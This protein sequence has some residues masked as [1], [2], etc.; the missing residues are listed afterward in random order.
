MNTFLI[1]ILLA[2]ADSKASWFPWARLRPAVNEPFG[3]GLVGLHALSGFV[4]AGAP[5]VLLVRGILGYWSPAALWITGLFG[6][7]TAALWFGMIRQAWNRRRAAGAAVM[8]EVRL[9]SIERWLALPLLTLLVL[10]V[11]GS[12]IVALENLRG[13]WQL[14]TV[15]KGFAAR[16]QATTLAEVVP[17]P[18]PAGS[19]FAEAPFLKPLFAYEVRKPEPGDTNG[20]LRWLDP[21]GFQQV[22]NF[23]QVEAGRPSFASFASQ[24]RRSHAGEAKGKG[25]AGDDRESGGPKIELGDEVWIK[26]GAINLAI[27]QAYYRSL[28]NG[29][30]PDPAASPAKDILAYLDR[31][32]AEYG[33]LTDA[34]AE[35]PMCRFPIRYEDGSMTV[36]SHLAPMKRFVLFLRLRAVALLADGQVNEAFLDVKRALQLSDGLRREPMLIS[37]MVRLA[38]DNL[39]TQPVWEGC[40]DRR[41]TDAQLAAFQEAFAGRDY[42]VELQKV[43]VGERVLAGVAYDAMAAG[44][45]AFNSLGIIDDSSLAHDDFNL[46]VFLTLM[47]RGWVRQSQVAHIQYVQALV[48]DVARARTYSE[49]TPSDD[50]LGQHINK[51]S[52]FNVL[53]AMLAPSVQHAAARVYEQEARR[54]LVMVGLALERYRLADGRYPEALEAL[55]PRFL[56]SVPMDP[57]DGKPLRYSRTDDDHFRLYSI[58]R[59]R[60]DDGGLWSARRDRNSGEHKNASDLVWR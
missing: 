9:S 10:V 38:L 2:S 56:S 58:G 19:N 21:A 39:A 14:R 30:L 33:Q 23:L 51:A 53:A 46:R 1:R 44:S 16:G 20:A 18:I 45:G 48:D 28:T 29:L 42:L 13:T 27:W 57:M 15:E 49:L 8:E 17:P 11:S 54:R 24:Y 31:Q 47:P 6:A 59:D 55:A 12:L 25:T 7:V 5:M 26:G 36:V 3:L 4:W 43:L 50:L 37:L 34:L 40:R 22:Q 35:R 60:A 32:R 41:W 52:L